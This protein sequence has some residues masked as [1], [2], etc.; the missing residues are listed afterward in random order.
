MLD[1]S[2][3]RMLDADKSFVLPLRLGDGFDEFRYNQLVDSI[4][5]FHNDWIG[6]EVIPKKAAMLFVEIGSVVAAC[7]TMYEG[8]ER[9]RILEAAANGTKLSGKLYLYRICDEIP[10]GRPRPSFN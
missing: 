8:A 3:Q 6:S 9:E 1:N 7:H 5:D 2:V 4:R 10:G